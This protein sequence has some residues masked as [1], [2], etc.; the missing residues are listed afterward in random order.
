LGQAGCQ[1]L[2]LEAIIK[3]E[4]V[5]RR[6]KILIINDFCNINGGAAGV[7]IESA[8]G[9][10]RAGYVTG[11]LG[12]VGPVDERMEL[13]GVAVVCA[14]EDTFLD[15]G[16]KVKA[17]W[18]GWWNSRVDE[19]LDRLAADFSPG[20]TIVHVHGWM[21]ALSP[22][23]FSFLNKRGYRF[24]VTLHDYFIA[25]PNGGF[26]DYPRV[27]ICRRTALSI[28]CLS[29][30]CDSRSYS[31]KLWRYGRGLIQNF[32]LQTPERANGF[33]GVS[34]FSLEKLEKYIGK[35]IPRSVVRNPVK[36]DQGCGTVGGVPGGPLL[37]VGRLSR[38]KGP[39]L[40]AE[41]SKRLGRKIVFVGDGEERKS[42]EHGYPD[43]IFEGW[44]PL[45]RVTELMTQASCLIFPSLWF[46][47]N[48]LVVLEA[49]ALGLPVIVANETAP[50]E[51]VKDGITGR[52][53][54][55]GDIDDLTAILK[56]L[57][58]GQGID[59]ARA[60]YDWYWSDPWT[61]ENHVKELVAFYQKLKHIAHD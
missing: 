32:A 28:S 14:N 54:K 22:S 36:I 5:L 27:E 2:L 6:M 39:V 24:V 50:T 38:E 46:E 20:E 19:L 52:V 17:A 37:F 41:A 49:I 42:L 31:Q 25:C 40:A 45:S 34:H 15:S 26:L 30:N 61:P 23:I 55:T 58:E 11:F 51:F 1:G 57:L 60:A 7:A 35:D 33:I 16:S 4:N 3:N 53:F 13:Q 18:R 43:A 9:L 12:M 8:L 10:A 29:C 21:K 44:Q 48:G 56:E 47:T 59:L